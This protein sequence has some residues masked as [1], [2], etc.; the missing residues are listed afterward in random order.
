MGKVILNEIINKENVKL[1]DIVKEYLGCLLLKSI[2]YGRKIFV[3]FILEMLKWW[4]KEE[5]DDEK[6]IK[7]SFLIEE[8]KGVVNNYGEVVE[9]LKFGFDKFND[10]ILV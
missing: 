10:Y 3:D 2:L 1:V 6:I 8:I 5:Y 7:F 9:I 4:K